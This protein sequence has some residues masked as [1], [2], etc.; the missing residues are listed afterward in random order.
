MRWALHFGDCGGDLTLQIYQVSELTR[1]I[2]GILEEEPRLLGLAVEGELSNF[3]HHS[4][5]HMYFSL[6]DQKSVVNCVM[7]AR[8]NYGLDFTPQDG[9][10]VV[11]L[12]QIGV[13][14][15]RGGYQLYV[16]QMLEAGEGALQRAFEELKE[17]L[18]KE[19][20]FD[21]ARKRSLPFMPQ[22]VGVVTSPTGAAI[23]DI[24]SV[25]TRRHP[26]IRIVLAPALVQGD[27][28]PQSI[29]DALGTIDSWGAADVIIVGRGGG[30]L[31]ELW[32]FND[33]RVARAIYSCSVPVVSAVG[34]ETDF[35]IADFVADQRA[36]TPSAA[37]ELVVPD[38]R[39]LMQ[40]LKD[41]SLRIQ[42]IMDQRIQSRLE[43]VN[44]LSKRRAL[45]L[46]Q[47]QVNQRYQRLD[48]LGR[49]L[50][51]GQRQLKTATDHRL[52]KV[53]ARLNSLSPLATLSRGYAIC[54]DQTGAII[55]KV[56]QMSD[57]DE[58]WIQFSDGKTKARKF[59]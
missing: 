22:C 10:H 59:S 16:S 55:A 38:H 40:R 14:E 20:L 1:I 33:E 23:R 57:V 12:G 35:T 51:M 7:F 34:H 27:G 15:K 56:A 30:S 50:E 2:K 28:A 17:K 49:R 41:I 32:A 31:E 13:Y 47:D 5:G 48:E 24:I 18:R 43:H 42:V 9:M 45:Q 6:K 44:S 25:L 39:Q 26:G 29:V 58:F 36:P 54:H 21:A 4:S 37:A 19:G 53:A 3:K 46:P 11:C 8:Q 52:E